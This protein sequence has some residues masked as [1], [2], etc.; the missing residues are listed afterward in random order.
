MLAAPGLIVA[1]GAYDGIM[2]AA[3]P[4]MERALDRLKAR[5]TDWPDDPAASAPLSPLDIFRKV[6]FDW[7][8]DIE[9]NYRGA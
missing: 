3:I 6:G 9:R 7:W 1:P 8:S 5:E 2:G 4:A